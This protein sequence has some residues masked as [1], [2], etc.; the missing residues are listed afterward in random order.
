MSRRPTVRPR[1]GRGTRRARST[2]GFTLIE[3]LVVI[4]I[5]AVLIALLLPAVQQVRQAAARMEASDN[6]GMVALAESLT[7]YAM[8]SESNLKQLTLAVET[9]E[10][11]YPRAPEK[12][13]GEKTVDRATAAEVEGWLRQFCAMEAEGRAL[14]VEIDR[15]SRSANDEDGRLLTEARGPLETMVRETG[16]S[17]EKAFTKL[18]LERSRVCRVAW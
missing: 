10:E 3:L 7:S 14:L 13:E 18:R 12:T 1:P 2:P 15:L 11:R 9:Y 5:I 6:P 16:G 4:A 17:L 8:K